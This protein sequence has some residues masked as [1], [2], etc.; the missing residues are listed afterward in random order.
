MAREGEFQ[1]ST[2]QNKAVVRA[3][4]EDVWNKQQ[5]DLIDQYFTEDALEHS[6]AGTNNRETIK[7][8]IP[9]ILNGIP[10]LKIKINMM[11]AEG[12]QVAVHETV[13]GTQT[14]E[15]LGIPPT[16]KHFS[17]TGTTIIRLVGGK[18]A[19]LWVV[20]DNLGMMQ[21]L[22]VIPAPEAVQA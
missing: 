9:V 8:L 14:G 17:I 21:Q 12:E 19:E 7:N 15:F 4:L 20:N 5:A 22:G 10:D 2:E 3:Y 1:I 13:S 11:V 16:G 6:S 18:I